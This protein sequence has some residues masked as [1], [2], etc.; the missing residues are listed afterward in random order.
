MKHR[1]ILLGLILAGSA[2]VGSR[3]VLRAEDAPKPGAG[4]LPDVYYRPG[5]PDAKYPVWVNEANMVTPSGSL[6]TDLVPASESFFIKGY[7][8]SPPKNG[9]IPVGT[10][11]KDFNGFPFRRTIEEATTSSRLTVLGIVTDEAPGFSGATPGQL[12]R[13]EPNEILKGHARKV[14]AYYV[15]FPVG[16]VMLGKTKLCK[17]DP[18]YPEA[19]RVGDRVLL[20]APDRRPWVEDDPFLDIMD[21]GGVVTL[22]HEGDVLLPDRYRPE[23]KSQTIGAPELLDRIR[24][25]GQSPQAVPEVTPEDA[26]SHQPIPAFP[27]T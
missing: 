4:R 6:N 12:L 8:S 27:P 25:A 19:P 1:S 24:R 20:F 16:Q 26:T 13:V 9:C 17:T 10:F 2:C 22:R 14:D 21:D 18:R 3:N 23:T 5:D 11:F 7:L 15:F